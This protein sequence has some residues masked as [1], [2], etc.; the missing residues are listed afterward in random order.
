VVV[1]ELAEQGVPGLADVEGMLDKGIGVQIGLA[2]LALGP[3]AA[4]EPVV[5]DGAGVLLPP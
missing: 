5:G 1:G 3:V 4:E 2:D